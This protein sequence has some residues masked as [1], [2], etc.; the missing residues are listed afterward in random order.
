MNRST[1]HTIPLHTP[2]CFRRWS[3]KTYAAFSSIGREV[4]IGHVS[5][6]ITDASLSKQTLPVGNSV[7]MVDG[8]LEPTTS[9][10]VGCIDPFSTILVETEWIAIPCL[11]QEYAAPAPLI[12]ITI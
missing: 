9:V 8:A 7:D 3:R 6:T 1:S 10:E 2:L 11:Q 4:T 5:K 12:T